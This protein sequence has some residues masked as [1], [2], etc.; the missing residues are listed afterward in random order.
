MTDQNA[1]D[2][3]GNLLF[4]VSRFNRLN[5][6]PDPSKSIADVIEEAKLFAS[7]GDDAVAYR[8]LFVYMLHASVEK[9]VGIQYFQDLE[10]YMASLDNVA[11]VLAP[12]GILIHL[13][14]QI[15]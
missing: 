2:S 3:N 8:W 15:T 7:Q 9:D 13:L 1:L 11:A 10:H 5:F 4:P 6:N 12:Q 14:E